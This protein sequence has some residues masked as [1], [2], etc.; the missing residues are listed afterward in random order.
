MHAMGSQYDYVCVIMWRLQSWQ[1]VSAMFHGISYHF[2]CYLLEVNM[3]LC[4]P[5]EVIW[6]WKGGPFT[7]QSIPNRACQQQW[8]RRCQRYHSR[9]AIIWQNY[10]LA[11]AVTNGCQPNSSACI[12]CQY[13]MLSGSTVGVI[14]GWSDCMKYVV[15]V[16]QDFDESG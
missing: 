3:S 2:R 14:I 7:H 9:I 11:L 16:W 8:R 10:P 12:T 15:C 1:R 6:T 5:V 4:A 13:N